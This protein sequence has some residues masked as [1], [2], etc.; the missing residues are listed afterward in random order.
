MHYRGIKG[1]L[2]KAIIL[3]S[4]NIIAC[5]THWFICIS[6]MEYYTFASNNLILL[7]A[8]SDCC[9]VSQQDNVLISSIL[10]L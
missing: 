1:K 8:D 5:S 7:D 4:V 9:S 6:W 3:N 10:A 2:S